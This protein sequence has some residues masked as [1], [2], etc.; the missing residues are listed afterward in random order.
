MNSR[1]LLALAF[2]AG[3]GGGWFGKTG[4]ALQAL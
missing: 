1:F 4:R 3:L 2:V